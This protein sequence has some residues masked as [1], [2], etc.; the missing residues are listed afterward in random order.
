MRRMA[1]LGPVSFDVRAESAAR[2]EIRIVN[3]SFVAGK[4]FTAVSPSIS[5]C[6]YDNIT[7]SGIPWSSAAILWHKWR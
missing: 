6:K 2:N 4:F 1:A 5:P 7:L 3:C